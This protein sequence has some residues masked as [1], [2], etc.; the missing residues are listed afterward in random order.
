MEEE[1]EKAIKIKDY[2]VY[3]GENI[4]A[5]DFIEYVNGSTRMNK[6]DKFD[7]EMDKLDGR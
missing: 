2:C 7:C 6:Q 5:S 3:T 4:S 1:L